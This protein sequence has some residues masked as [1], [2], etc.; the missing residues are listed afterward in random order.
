MAKSKRTAKALE[1]RARRDRWLNSMFE[2]VRS[3]AKRTVGDKQPIAEMLLQE[4]T[5]GLTTRKSDPAH[6]HLAN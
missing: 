2:K 5:Q 1:V 6:V 4:D 3:A